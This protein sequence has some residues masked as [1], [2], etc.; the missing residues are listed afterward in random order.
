MPVVGHPARRRA[1]LFLFAGALTAWGVA[2]GGHLRAASD[3]SAPPD[4]ETRV[5]LVE[6]HAL[7]SPVSIEAAVATAQ[8]LRFNTIL[9]DARALGEV[10]FNHGLE[11]RAASL[12]GEPATFDPL[13]AAIAIARARG[14]R[15]HARVSV[16][17]VASAADLPA[18]RAHLVNAHPEWL[19]VPRALARDLT[20][21]DAGSQLFLDRLLRWTRAQPPD[22]T[23]LYASPVS[24]EAA[25]AL[26]ALV[27]DLA[28]RY[29]VDGIQLEDVA[30]PTPEFDYSR[31]A[32]EAFKADVLGG[33][34]AQAKRDRE[35]EIGADLTAWPDAMPDRWAEFRRDRLTALVARIRRGIRL[36]RPEA[37]VSAA[38]APEVGGGGL[39]HFQDWRAWSDRRLLDAVCPAADT[40]DAAAF[41]AQI[42]DARRAAGDTPVWTQV[43]AFRLSASEAV[44]RIRTARQLGARGIII[45]SYGSVM[46]VPD[47]LDYLTRIAHA[48]F[49]P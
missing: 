27:A 8:A 30:Y 2:A 31:A 11:P 6:R 40:L 45:G 21:L 9:L 1:C 41:A 5:L 3:S 39:Q 47:G 13:A 17:L 34:D 26:V 43:G 23:G 24:D 22:N 7:A 38:V 28:A 12:A 14:I 20:L 44:D 15:V 25:D 4:A 36:R 18:A 29:P 37:I 32:L 49:E 10:Y 42:G 35:R 16:S 19:M 48:A 46:S 33:L